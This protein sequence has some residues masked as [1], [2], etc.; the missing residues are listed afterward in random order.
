MQRLIW[1]DRLRGLAIMSVVI[2][3]SVFNFGSG[4]VFLKWIS[5]ANM[6]V[7]F[8]VSGYIAAY[9]EREELR[10]QKGAACFIWHKTIQLILPFITWGLVINRYF[11]TTN[12]TMINFSD[13]VEEW[14]HPH[15]WF[16]LTLY[17]Y[18]CLLTVERLVIRKNW[19]RGG[20]L[21]SLFN[22]SVCF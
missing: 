10:M 21:D 2:Q 11:F 17:A 6:G 8:F 16:L 20:V 9:G 7:F 4:F 14:R 19:I 15:L 22:R 13:I 12:W 18:F 3:H 5:I 1:P